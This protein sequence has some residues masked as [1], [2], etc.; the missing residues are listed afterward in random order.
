MVDVDRQIEAVTRALHHAE[1]DG[2]PAFMQTLA[3]TFDAPIEVVWEAV[4][5]P[6][7][8]GRWFLPVRGELGVGGRFQLEGHAGGRVLACNPPRDGHADYTV[9]WAFEGAPD[10]WVTLTLDAVGAATRFELEHISRADD[11]PVGMWQQF[12][13]GAT[14]AGWDGAILGLAIDLHAEGRIDDFDA[15]QLSDE[16]RRFSRLSADAWRDADVAAGTDPATAASRADETY[17]FYTGQE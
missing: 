13:P 2:D 11:L 16:G 14:G 3:Q 6:E 8:I 1:H 4:T 17:A 10:S 15:W 12:G 7:H 9:T 5:V